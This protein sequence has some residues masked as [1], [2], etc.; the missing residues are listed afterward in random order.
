MCTSWLDRP[1]QEVVT[2]IWE[3]IL[4]SKCFKQTALSIGLANVLNNA[5]FIFNQ[6]T[7]IYVWNINSCRQFLVESVTEPLTTLLC[8]ISQCTCGVSVC[9]SPIQHILFPPY[10]SLHITEHR[11]RLGLS[12]ELWWLSAY[13]PLIEYTLGSKPLI[14]QSMTSSGHHHHLR[15]IRGGSPG[16]TWMANKSLGATLILKIECSV[17]V[18]LLD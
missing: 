1:E 9:P 17:F 18:F 7:F 13:R 4:I 5:E 2:D 15:L 6:I 8:S 14:P 3:N 11:L 12:P 16:E 10:I